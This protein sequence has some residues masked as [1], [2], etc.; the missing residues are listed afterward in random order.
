MGSIFE[1]KKGEGNNLG[2]GIFEIAILPLFRSFPGKVREEN[3]SRGEGEKRS[4]KKEREGGE[5]GIG[6]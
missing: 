4:L 1:G 6:S 5:R 2:K 3:D